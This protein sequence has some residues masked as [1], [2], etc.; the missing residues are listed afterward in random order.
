MD[1]EIQF[2]LLCQRSGSAVAHQRGA[3]AES[4]FVGTILQELGPCSKSKERQ[5]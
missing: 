3:A 1:K 2:L 5:T 4:R